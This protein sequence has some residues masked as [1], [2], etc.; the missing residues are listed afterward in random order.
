LTDCANELSIKFG[1]RICQGGLCC[2]QEVWHSKFNFGAEQMTKS[3]LID[4][5]SEKANITRVKAELVVTTV[6]D[7]MVTAIRQGHRIEVR[8]FGSF[9]V[10]HYN[11]YKGRN[12]RSGEVIEVPEKVIPF[13]K[14]G[15]NLKRQVNGKTPKEDKN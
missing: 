1:L 12:P 8:D 10:R 13:F 6:F 15:R 2:I 3:G 5:I 7:S 9:E 14:V 11:P 4:L